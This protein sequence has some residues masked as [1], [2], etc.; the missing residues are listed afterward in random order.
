VLSVCISHKNRAYVQIPG[1]ELRPLFR[2]AFAALTLSLSKISEPSEVVIA[3]FSDEQ[4][5]SLGLWIAECHGVTVRVIRGTGDFTIGA[6]RN[7]A[8]GVA[9][10]DKL[11]FMDADMLCPVA[12]IRRA[13][14]VMAEGKAFAP[15]YD[16]LNPDGSVAE[17]GNGTGNL[18]CLRRHLEEAGP[19]IEAHEWANDGDTAMWHWFESHGLAAPREFVP[20]F[21]HQWHPHMEHS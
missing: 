9:R 18:F 10:G 4:R 2:L 6:G 16:R 11:F 3:D 12:V 17:R 14:E 1:G 15:F 7:Q 21:V 5:T 13:L 8:A 20:G 19:W